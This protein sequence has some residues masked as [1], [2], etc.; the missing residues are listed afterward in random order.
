MIKNQI[1]PKI[2][3]NWIA[4]K[5]TEALSK[6]LFD[7]LNPVDGK[8]LCQVVRSYSEDIK[9]AVESAKYAQLAWKLP[10]IFI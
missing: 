1:I 6:E 5:E 10:E 9:Q 8:R 3:P 4:G 2:V 7:K